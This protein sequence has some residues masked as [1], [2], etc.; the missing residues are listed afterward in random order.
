LSFINRFIFY[1]NMKISTLSQVIVASAFPAAS[2]AGSIRGGR[3]LSPFDP[4]NDSSVH[5]KRSS[6]QDIAAEPEEESDVDG[7]GLMQ[8][9]IIGGA[10][11]SIARRRAASMQFNE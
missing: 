1:E 11:V 5:K 3:K 10:V 8:T 2:S 6:E 4:T 7:P 9:R